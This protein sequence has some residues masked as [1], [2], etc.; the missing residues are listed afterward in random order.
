ML[1]FIENMFSKKLDKEHS[2][3]QYNIASEMRVAMV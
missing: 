1:R 3:W 2:A